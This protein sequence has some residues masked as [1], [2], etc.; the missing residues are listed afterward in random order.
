MYKFVSS[1]DVIGLSLPCQVISAIYCT[2][3][4]ALVILETGPRVPS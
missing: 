2:P 1:R 3:L 4:N